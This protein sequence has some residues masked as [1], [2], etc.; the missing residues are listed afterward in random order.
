MKKEWKQP[1][2]ETLHV[3]QTMKGG[4]WGWDGDHKDDHDH[5]ED[6]WPVGGVGDS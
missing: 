6:C 2:L 3:T 5:D 4:H 1:T